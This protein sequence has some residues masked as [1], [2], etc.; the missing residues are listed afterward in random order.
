[1]SKNKKIYFG[2]FFMGMVCIFS[3][4][5]GFG[6]LLFM[7]V[8]N[9]NHPFYIWYSYLVVFPIGLLLYKGIIQEIRR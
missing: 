6:F 8:A 2:M 9:L 3:A 1:M 5:T 7:K 4:M